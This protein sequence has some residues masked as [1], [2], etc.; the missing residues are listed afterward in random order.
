MGPARGRPEHAGGRQH[1]PVVSDE[2]VDEY[3][4]DFTDLV[5][6]VGAKLTTEGLIELNKRFDVDKEDASAIAT[7]WLTENGF[8]D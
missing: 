5:N 4:D 1:R 6:D 2:L 7:D 8:L 3:G